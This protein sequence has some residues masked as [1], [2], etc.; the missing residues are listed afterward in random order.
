MSGDLPL[1]FC[2]IPVRGNTINR[3]LQTHTHAC[4]RNG[5]HW[6]QQLHAARSRLSSLLLSSIVLSSSISVGG[7]VC[8]WRQYKEGN[9]KFVASKDSLWGRPSIFEEKYCLQT[10]I[11]VYS[12]QSDTHRGNPKNQLFFQSPRKFCFLALLGFIALQSEG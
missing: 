3:P 11:Q 2:D 9:T 12:K 5:I 6:A 1:L 10:C 8:Y 4:L 7:G